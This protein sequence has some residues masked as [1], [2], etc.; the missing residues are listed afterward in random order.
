[1]KNKYEQELLEEIL[2][3]EEIRY[4]N[5]YVENEYLKHLLD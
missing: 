3:D 1:M 2:N 4:D 5:D